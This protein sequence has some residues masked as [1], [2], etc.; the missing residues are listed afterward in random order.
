M[1]VAV[2]TPHHDGRRGKFLERL[3]HYMAAQTRKPDEWFIIDQSVLPWKAGTKD[4]TKRVRIGC[5][6]AKAS[7]CEAVLIME[8]DDWYSPDYIK[9]MLDMWQRKGKPQLFGVGY[10]L[11]FHIKASKYWMSRHEG[12]ASLMSTLIRTDA[13]ELFTWPSDNHI[14]L[15][16]DLWKQLKGATHNFSKLISTGIKHGIGDTGG[17]GHNSGFSK[18]RPDP[19]WSQLKMALSNE[20]IQFYKSLCKSSVLS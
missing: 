2:V 13:L 16:I 10:T 18:Y 9:L 5:D 1:R 17:V 7:G 19:A 12:R 6:M 11:Y 8:D 20:D 4:L 14:W 15:D 3:K